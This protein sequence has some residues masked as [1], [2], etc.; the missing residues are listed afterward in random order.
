[1]LPHSFTGKAALRGGCPMA[2]SASVDGLGSATTRALLQGSGPLRL[3]AVLLL[4]AC[5][6]VGSV[7]AVSQAAVTTA[8]SPDGTLGTLV[9]GSP[10]GLC[11]AGCS[12]SG[13]TIIKGINQFHSLG[14]F[15]VGTLDTATFD[16]P[17]NIVNI[18]SRVTGGVRS[19]VDGMLQTTIPGA[20]L[21]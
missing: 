7:S 1:M 12:I 4:S 10:T 9:N 5:I 11:T 14:L 17:P 15:S 20:N 6:H 21:F 16:G 3:I 13:G 8:I 19:D 18:L 2:H